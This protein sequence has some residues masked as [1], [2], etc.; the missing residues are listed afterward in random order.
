MLIG[1]VIRQSNP[2]K[3]YSQ[4][5]D[6][7]LYYL[8]PCFFIYYLIV[9]LT[10][11]IGI[12]LLLLRIKGGNFWHLIK[13]SFKLQVISTITPGRVGDIGL[14]YYLK[15]EY[16]SGQ[17]S[18]IL[19]IDKLI[20]FCINIIL[21][22]IGIGFFLSW[23]YAVIITLF[24][25][26][27]LLL[28]I[29]FLFKFPQKIIN[30]GFVRKIILSLQGFRV[31]LNSTVRNYKAITGNAILTLI[32][33]IFA[34]LVM[35]LTLLWFGQ[36]VTLINVILIQSVAQLATFIPLTIMGLGVTEAVSVSLFGTI[37]IPSEI[38][39]AA[40]LWSRAIYLI[41]IVCVYLLWIAAPFFHRLLPTR[42]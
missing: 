11:A 12:Y 1:V 8:I 21:S 22:T 39:L 20:T 36:H 33:C 7:P 40:L 31:E 10:W 41:F 38:V 37:G 26:I 27:I 29:Y 19:F 34:G 3:I 28:M 25:T 18:A 2:E 35:L 9:V 4:L 17:I 15:K 16:T 23:N 5:I 14:L 30:R 24:T 32:R 6:A 42:H 13:T